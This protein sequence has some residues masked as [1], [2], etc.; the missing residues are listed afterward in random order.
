M[1]RP[2]SLFFP[3][4]SLSSPNPF[5]RFF[6]EE[7]SHDRRGWGGVGRSGMVLRSVL[8]SICLPSHLF[9]TGWPLPRGNVGTVCIPSTHP[10]TSSM[11]FFRR[12]PLKKEKKK[13]TSFHEQLARRPLRC[14][15]TPSFS[16]TLF[17][18]IFACFRSFLKKRR[19]LRICEPS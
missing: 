3:L 2:E 18:R 9:S 12:K 1:R 14:R 15:R 8:H 17:A 7:L 11:F 10:A 4:G 16:R 5:S 6:R 13:N 19:M